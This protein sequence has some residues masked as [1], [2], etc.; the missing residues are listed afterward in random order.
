[1]GFKVHAGAARIRKA[2][3]VSIHYGKNIKLEYHTVGEYLRMLEMCQLSRDKHT[4][5]THYQNG[6]TQFRYGTKRNGFTAYDKLKDLE[7]ANKRGQDYKTYEKD[8]DCQLK[9]FDEREPASG[10]MLRF[11]KRLNG[12]A[13]VYTALNRLGFIE[14]R[15]DA[16]LQTLFSKDIAQKVLQ[17]ELEFHKKNHISSLA[18]K[19]ADE[20]KQAEQLKKLNP[21]VNPKDL[22]SAMQFSSLI[23]RYDYQTLAELYSDNPR[24]LSYFL[25]CYRNIKKPDGSHPDILDFISHRLEEFEKMSLD[26]V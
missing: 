25:K 4:G 11:E 7:F 22:L 23:E 15:D 19:A 10:Q 3:V 16:I 6:G 26:G 12:K 21:G 2:M 1:M 24:Q 17:T 9:L 20:L 13:N 14:E 5:K 8:Y 18:F